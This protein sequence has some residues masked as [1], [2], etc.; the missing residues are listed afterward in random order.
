[1]NR[2]VFV[3]VA[4][5]PVVG[6]LAEAHIARHDQVWK[7]LPDE[8]DGEDDGTLWIIGGCTAVV[9]FGRSFGCIVRRERLSAR[10]KDARSPEEIGR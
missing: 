8:L 9:L 4:A 3:Q 1:M 10:S 6:V 2:S 5:V 7:L